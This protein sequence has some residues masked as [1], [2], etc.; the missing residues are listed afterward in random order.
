MTHLFPRDFLKFS[1]STFAGPAFSPFL[2][3]LGT[4]EVFP[5]AGG[6]RW[7]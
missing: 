1:A 7:L 3:G 4:F 6:E 5:T 2:P